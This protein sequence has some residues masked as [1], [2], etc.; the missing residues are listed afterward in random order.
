[1][2]AFVL[3]IDL[4]ADAMQAPA[5]VAGALRQIADDL[6]HGWGAGAASDGSIRD[7]NG[8]TVG[9]WAAEWP[10]LDAAGRA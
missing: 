8:N 10:E 1:M 9:R 7:E 5:H 2:S 3:R 4:G 6:T